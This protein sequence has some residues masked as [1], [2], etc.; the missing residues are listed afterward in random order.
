MCKSIVEA[1]YQ[2]SLKNPQKMI[3]ADSVNSYNYQEFISTTYKT[4]VKMSESGIEK[5]DYVLV[6]CTQDAD[7]IIMDMACECI[8]AIFVPLEK[9]A[10]SERVEKIYKDTGAVCIFSN[11]DYSGVGKT[12]DIRT[13]IGDKI[14]H[15]DIVFPETETD[16]LAEILFSTGTTG[17]P[18]GICISNRANIAIAENIKYGTEMNENSVEMIPLPLSH[19]HG[20][21]TCY[22]NFLNGS[23]VVIIDGVMNVALFFSMIEKYGVN[24]LDISPTLAKLL[25]K[26]AK[27]L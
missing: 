18:K 3:I 24:A 8:G 16:A 4:S 25:L 13:F 6:E 21:R 12:V 23:S 11:T 26:I 7:F 14:T 9:K 27:N 15:A 20:L 22:A 1:I 5:G 17:E 19:S 10:V 2:H